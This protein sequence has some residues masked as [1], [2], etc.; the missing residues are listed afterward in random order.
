MSTHA[1]L[2]DTMSSIV[3]SSLVQINAIGLGAGM[4]RENS[5]SKHSFKYYSTAFSTNP[6]NQRKAT[7]KF[8]TE[9]KW[10]TL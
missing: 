9:Q 5:Q 1:T 7:D 3:I 10:G 6:Y 2:E 8:Y 4:M